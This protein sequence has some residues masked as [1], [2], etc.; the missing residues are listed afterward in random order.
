ML[1]HDHVQSITTAAKRLGRE[2]EGLKRDYRDV[3][4]NCHRNNT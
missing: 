3:E 2:I 1:T 4:E